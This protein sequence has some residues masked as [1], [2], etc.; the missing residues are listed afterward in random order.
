MTV[1]SCELGTG[2]KFDGEWD[3]AWLWKL[4]QCR[5]VC[6]RVTRRCKVRHCE[7]ETQTG[8]NEIVKARGLAIQSKRL[9]WS[10]G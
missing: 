7:G 8:S 5:F 4:W 3:E 1:D 10:A 9:N 6:V 2:Q